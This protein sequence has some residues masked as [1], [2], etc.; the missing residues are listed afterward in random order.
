MSVAIID[1]P[2]TIPD[3]VAALASKVA[4]LGGY[5]VY[6]RR[7]GPADT[8]LVCYAVPEERVRGLAR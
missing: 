7:Y 4:S 3:A 8:E 5:K 2:A 1:K 6:L